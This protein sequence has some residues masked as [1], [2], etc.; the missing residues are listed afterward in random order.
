MRARYGILAALV[1]VP[2]ALAIGGG[3]GGSSSD[4]S[5]NNTPDAT[6]DVTLDTAPPKQDSAPDVTDAA[7][8]CTVD[9]DLNNINV[10]DAALGDAGATVSC[11]ITC[12]KSACST[13]LSACNADC[14]CKGALL[15]VFDCMKTGQSL[16][17]CALAA[18]GQLDPNTQQTLQTLGFCIYGACG[19][20]CGLT[21]QTG[22]GGKPDAAGDAASD[23]P[24]DA[25]ADGG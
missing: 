19:N 23:A 8:V 4:N 20:Q 2:V 13:E 16:Q 22:D 11:L 9:A 24:S 7:K 21:Q 6:A 25:P 10:P 17:A 14:D 15:S 12:G 5:G 1:G 3:C 18:S